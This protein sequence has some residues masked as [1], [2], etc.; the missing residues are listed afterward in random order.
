VLINHDTLRELVGV[1]SYDQV[2]YYHMGWVEEYLGDGNTGRGIPVK[3][4]L[5][6]LS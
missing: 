4:S 2:N 3:E 1:V 5:E 6:H